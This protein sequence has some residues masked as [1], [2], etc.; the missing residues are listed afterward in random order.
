MLNA[1]RQMPAKAER[2][3]V[4]HGGAARDPVSG[5][6]TNPRRDTES[7]GSELLDAILTR[8]NLRQA[9]KSVKA[10]K[11]AA[12]ADGLEINQAAR[13]LVT[14]WPKIRELLLRGAYRPGPVRRV[15][16]A[17]P[18]G[19]ERELG[20]QTVTGRPIQQALPQVLQPMIDPTL[21]EHSYGFRPGRRAH[22]AIL[23]AQAYVQS[24]R[25]IVVDFE[26][27][28][29]LDR[30]NHDIVIDR[31]KKRIDGAGFTR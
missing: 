7:A 27:E 9:W 31:L 13:H 30:V 18:D 11:G 22:D 25:K 2:A 5:E 29:F 4:T 20:I 26:L 6:A 21:S 10:D 14:A 24:G 3:G 12:G 8:E 1:T 23:A 19:G 17:K 16:I 15:T 28:K